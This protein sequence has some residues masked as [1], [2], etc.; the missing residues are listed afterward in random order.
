MDSPKVIFRWAGTPT[1]AD[2]LW[3]VSPPANF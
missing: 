1:E 2:P 3:P